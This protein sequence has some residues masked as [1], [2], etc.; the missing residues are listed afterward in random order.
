MTG[1]ININNFIN[2]K[3]LGP[4]SK[5]YI[6][7]LNPSN[8]RVFSKI[9]DS[10]EKD[11]D[12]AIQAAQSAYLDWSKLLPEQR[13]QWLFKLAEKIKEKQIFLAQAETLDNGKPL[14]LALKV[15]IP[16]AAENFE[17]FAKFS[18]QNSSETFEM[19]QATNYSSRNSL[20]VVVCISPWNLPL[21]L[22]TW[23]IAPAIAAGNTVVAKPSEITPYTAFL[24]SQILEE[25]T[26][27]KG[28]INIV[29]GTGSE[30]GSFLTKDSRVKA[31]SFTG[32]T[33]T[34]KQIYKNAVENF[35]KVS[36]E[37]GGKNPTIVFADCDFEKTVKETVRAA[38]TNQGQICLCGSRILVEASI[39]EKFKL[40]LVDEIKKLKV[41]NPNDN[42][43][44]QG[45]IV[46]QEHYDKILTYI[47]L[48]K[49]E[50][51][52]VLIGGNP[53]KL[54]GELE[55]GLFIEPTLIENLEYYCRT[56]QEEIFGPV[57]TI[58]RFQEEAQVIAWAN[59]TNYGLAG[60]IWSQDITKAKRI[61]EKIDSGLLWI[62]CWMVRDL[63][64]PFGGMKDSG[65]GREG[66]RYALE[67]FT[68]P[69]N[70]CI[71][72]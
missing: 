26:F 5:K 25:I 10:N 30:C 4:D 44:D 29:H 42:E 3:F 24:F 41:G 7:N 52:K 1:L 64:T 19:D 16:R 45:A 14:S 70:I 65:V 22:F 57:A 21:Y 56:N 12:L 20:G 11:V 39:Y 72:N 38:Y 31:I 13:S 43:T 47:N 34:G 71:Q 23:K 40:A 61:A 49:K 37:M 17:F 9:A 35:T 54:K 33:N 48:A 55:K 62:N 69:K 27:P 63:R 46:S 36:L 8:G 51:G 6:D 18:K 67:F 53:V 32:S 66:G 60:S 50:G 15:D 28:V 68:E 2:G 58:M 59:S